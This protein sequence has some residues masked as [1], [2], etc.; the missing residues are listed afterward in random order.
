MKS[1]IRIGKVSKVNYE[2]GTVQVTYADRDDA[3]TGDI[4]MVSNAL[5]RM[6]AVDSLVCVA[7]NSDSQEM[8]TCIGTFWNDEY[9]PVDGKEKL[10]RYDYNDKQG[11]AFEMYEG[12]TGDYTETIDGNVKETVGKNVEYTVKGDMTFKVGGATVKVCQSGAVEIKGTTI[13]IDGSTVNINGGSG[14]CVI[15]GVSLVNHKHTHDGGDK[16]NGTP[17]VGLTGVPQK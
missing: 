13:S 10:Y 11:K 3:V 12:D 7:H 15:S 9:K 4:C 14:D 5:Y 17:V 16:V 8:G 1:T 2:A 6:P